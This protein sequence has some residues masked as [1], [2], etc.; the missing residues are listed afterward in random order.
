ML[1]KNDYLSLYKDSSNGLL[2]PS[3]KEHWKNIG[4][5]LWTELLSTP[6]SNGNTGVPSRCF[7]TGFQAG[8][9]LVFMCG[10]DDGMV[11]CHDPVLKQCSPFLREVL[12]RNDSKGCFEKTIVLPD[13]KSDILLHCLKLIYTGEGEVNEEELKHVNELF[14]LLKIPFNL[15][16][17]EV[18][19]PGEK[20][21]LY[22]TQNDPSYF[23]ENRC[24]LIPQDAI[25]DLETTIAAAPEKLIDCEKAGIDDYVQKIKIEDHPMISEMLCTNTEPVCESNYR[26]TVDEG[27]VV[28]SSIQEDLSEFQPSIS[29]GMHVSIENDLRIEGNEETNEIRKVEEKICNDQDEEENPCQDKCIEFNPKV[30]LQRV[31]DEVI[32]SKKIY[33]KK[34]FSR[35]TIDKEGKTKHSQKKAKITK[36][37]RTEA[38]KNDNKK[39]IR[40]K[41]RKLRTHLNVHCP[42]CDKQFSISSCTNSDV[43]SHIA[44]EHLKE[45]ILNKY[46]DLIVAAERMCPIPG[47]NLKIYGESFHGNKEITSTCSKFSLP[48]ADKFAAGVAITFHM[49]VRHY[50][51]FDFLAKHQVQQLRSTLS[52]GDIPKSILSPVRRIPDLNGVYS[53]TAREVYAESIRDNKN[54]DQVHMK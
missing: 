35:K 4:V 32:Y 20:K 19:R 25:N 16:E 38:P 30:F 49:G 28:L 36:Q 6:Y 31:D 24:V 50:K 13:T 41:L 52:I 26:T 17:E 37:F 8:A 27:S 9:N 40:I 10:G 5:G 39:K 3:K 34:I 1:R 7:P 29:L 11:A 48:Q 22:I 51:V 21:S 47:C 14:N 15:Y 42:V 2:S 54:Q 46:Q 44:E 12:D 18:Q 53:S 43:L 45:E 33:R 23:E